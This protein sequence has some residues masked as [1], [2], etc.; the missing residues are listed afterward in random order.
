MQV[1][2]IQKLNTLK[3]FWRA[4]SDLIGHRGVRNEIPLPNKVGEFKL[5]R[6]ILEDKK[7]NKFQ[8]G[9][10]KNKSGKEYIAKQLSL[11]DPGIDEYWLRNEISV[12]SA[13]TKLYKQKGKIIKKEFPNTYIPKLAFII[14]DKIRLMFI[15]EKISGKTLYDFPM[16]KRVAYIEEAVGYFRFINSVHNFKVEIPTQRGIGHILITL[17]IATIGAL[18]RH[19]G[20]WFEIAQGI[21]LILIH[22]PFLIQQKEKSLIHRDIGYSNILV[23]KNNQKYIID[24]EL[25]SYM[26]PVWEIVQIVVG[27]WRR[28]GF[29]EAFSQSEEMLK[30]LND[31]K[32]RKIYKLFSLYCGIHL[33]S[34]HGEN[35]PKEKVK[36][37][38]KYLDYA[39]N[40]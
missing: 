4:I 3:S 38:K 9:L 31:H 36:S 37:S 22:T 16:K 13:L 30:I 17:C 8:Y 2:T 35:V 28:E 6:P 34:T 33:L 15:V 10:Y 27:C 24:F 29:N 23:G 21:V 14:D 11:K 18:K 39:L 12:Y 5:V 26:H 1:M 20:K 25:S 7:N 19:P 32:L 40:I